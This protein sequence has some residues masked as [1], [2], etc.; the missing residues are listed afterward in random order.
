MS[1][2]TSSY[3]DRDIFISPQQLVH[4]PSRC[5][6]AS[7]PVDRLTMKQAVEQVLE[8]LRN[9][10]SR[11]P[12]LIMGP[13]AQLVT[14]AQRNRRFAAA[15]KASDLN[16]PD[17]V[18][19]LIAAKMLGT[20]VPERVTGGDMMEQLCEKAAQHHLR[21][22]FLGGLPGAA[23]QA[24]LQLQSRYPG[25]SIAGTYCPPLGFEHDPIE[26]THIRQIITVAA[27]DLL[28]VAF[29]APKQEIW[30]HENCGTLPVKAALSVGAAF[31][32]QAGL[33]KRAP[34]WTH[35][36]GM[37]WFYRLLQE[38]RRLWRRYLV[39]NTYFLYLVLKQCLACG[40]TALKRHP[41]PSEMPEAEPQM[42]Y[43]TYP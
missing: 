24:A 34:E 27:P 5:I 35:K 22:F 6:V 7:V 20:P 15:L 4:A 26:S 32:T 14:L 41:S 33:R 12:F 13:N 37:E 23:D 42:Q 30:I 2:V 25:L 36:I 29:G 39:G 1:W 19:I 9:G 21:V 31:D 40:N 28:F 18:S 16:I 17:G 11:K 3:S 43:T 38:P 10:L 8:A